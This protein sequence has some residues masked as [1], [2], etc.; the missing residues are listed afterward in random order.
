MSNQ[1]V[2]LLFSN[3]AGWHGDRNL[4]DGA[5]NQTQFV[6][7]MEEVA[8]LYATINPELTTVGIARDLSGII[9]G[10]AIKGRIKQA[11]QGKTIADDVG[12][13]NVVLVNMV[14]REGLT[15]QH[16]LETAWADIID[17]K[18]KMINGMFVKEADL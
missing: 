9:N 11:P 5:T 14:E 13:I 4:I 17:R 8:E 12:D 18:G 3:I 7:L 16:C 15:M 6:K 1:G 2:P 10:L